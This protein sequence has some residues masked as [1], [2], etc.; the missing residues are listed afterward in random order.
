MLCQP[1]ENLEL[2]FDWTNDKN[3]IFGDKDGTEQKRLR[4]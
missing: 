2:T 4:R 3:F 1:K